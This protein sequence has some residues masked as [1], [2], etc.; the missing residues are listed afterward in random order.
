MA[1][2]LSLEGTMAFSAPP[3]KST[4]AGVPL[5]ESNSIPQSVFTIPSSPR[6]G[7]DPFFPNS[8]RFSGE[9]ALP[10]Q[11][12]PTR[13]DVILELQGI[14]GTPDHRLAIIYCHSGGE[15]EKAYR[16]VAEGEETEFKTATGRVRLRCIE[17]K[18]ESVV[19][20]VGGDRR[21]LRNPRVTR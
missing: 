6:Q 14:G 16:T 15:S 19:V 5:A 9:T 8:H 4:P 2:L 12:A 10:S 13:S 1:A 21:E 7:R 17:I 3:V 20:Q 18:R 11:L